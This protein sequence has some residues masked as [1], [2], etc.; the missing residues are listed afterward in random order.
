MLVVNVIR[1]DRV[2]ANEYEKL[3][4]VLRA[5]HQVH[6]YWVVSPGLRT[7]AI[8]DTVHDDLEDDN[9]GV[10]NK[11]TSGS[12]GVSLYAQLS[13][14]LIAAKNANGALESTVKKL[15]DVGFPVR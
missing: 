7:S 9:D 6:N 14:F 3:V 10:V 15:E 5:F 13:R 4:P 8:P 2:Q 1:D 12:R 11:C